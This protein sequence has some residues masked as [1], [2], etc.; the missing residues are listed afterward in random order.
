MYATVAPE[1]RVRLFGLSPAGKRAKLAR[2]ASAELAAAVRRYEIRRSALGL[3]ADPLA[4]ARQLAGAHPEQLRWDVVVDEYG[5]D[6]RAWI[7]VVH[8]S[9]YSYRTTP[10]GLEQIRASFSAPRTHRAPT[11]SS[12]R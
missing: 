7:A 2:G 10:N 3:F 1:V 12:K 9:T 8:R 6:E 4:V 5:L 11:G